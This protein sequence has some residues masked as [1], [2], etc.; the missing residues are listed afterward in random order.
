[1]QLTRATMHLNLDLRRRQADNRRRPFCRRNLLGGHFETLRPCSELL[2]IGVFRDPHA[3]AVEE[4]V[5]PRLGGC[6]AADHHDDDQ[7]KQACGDRS[8][9]ASVAWAPHETRR[10]HRCRPHGNKPQQG[11][12][13]KVCQPAP[14]RELRR[15]PAGP[16]RRELIPGTRAPCGCRSGQG[17][18]DWRCECGRQFH[19]GFP[20]EPARPLSQLFYLAVVPCSMACPTVSAHAGRQAGPSGVNDL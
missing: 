3:K 19:G 18:R 4:I 20:V 11:H 9:D 15:M 7:Q 6:H 12:H 10:K 13:Q 16:V 1:V 5:G 8:T 17:Q 14:L 2:N